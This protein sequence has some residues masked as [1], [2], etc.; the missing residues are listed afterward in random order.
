MALNLWLNSAVEQEQ[1]RHDAHAL[2]LAVTR[3]PG[4]AS[5]SFWHDKYY[6]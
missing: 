6:W 4:R 3:S 1:W 5:M 2:R